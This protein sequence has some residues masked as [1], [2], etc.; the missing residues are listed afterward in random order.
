MLVVPQTLTLSYWSPLKKREPCLPIEIEDMPA[1]P[2]LIWMMAE[3]C[4]KHGGL[5]MAAPQVGIHKTLAMVLSP[6]GKVYGLI[7]PKITKWY[8]RE[9]QELEGCLSVLPQGNSHKVWRSERI[10]L[11]TGTEADPHAEQKTSHVGMEARVIQHEIDHLNADGEIFF[12][13][14]LGP[15]AKGQVIRKYMK[16]LRQEDKHV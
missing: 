4:K 16:S 6:K 14:R 2:E 9:M 15:V 1:V 10:D 12:L 5:G 13:D 11:V 7:N 8:G 3:F